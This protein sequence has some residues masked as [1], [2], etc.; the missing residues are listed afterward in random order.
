[1]PVVESS[2]IVGFLSV[3]HILRYIQEDILGD[4]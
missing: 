3:R 1:M 4:G 2:K